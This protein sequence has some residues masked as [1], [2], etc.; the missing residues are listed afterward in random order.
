MERG[1]IDRTDLA[2]RRVNVIPLWLKLAFTALL[3]VMLPYSCSAYGPANLLYASDAAMIVTV[4]A[5]WT[6][7][8]IFT[9][10]QGIGILL[11]Q[12][13]W[14]IDFAIRG[15]AGQTVLGLANYM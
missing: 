5:L 2:P 10:L 7:S 11:P 12:T 14:V 9:S 6:E 4:V 13:L 8:R 15:V 3:A 1:M